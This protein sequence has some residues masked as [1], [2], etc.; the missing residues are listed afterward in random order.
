MTDN[1]ASGS[2][3]TSLP[4][5]TSR[6]RPTAC[7]PD[8]SEPG[9]RMPVRVA[10]VHSNEEMALKHLSGVQFGTEGVPRLISKYLELKSYN[11]KPSTGRATAS[12]RAVPIRGNKTLRFVPRI[13]RMS[14]TADN[15]LDGQ[16]RLGTEAP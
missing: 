15:R 8:Y 6:V 14:N 7:T 11:I 1:I 16:V 4:S 9:V 2:M 13:P 3:V 12:C 10:L 5:L